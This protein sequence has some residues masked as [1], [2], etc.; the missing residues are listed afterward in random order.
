[1]VF[2][3]VPEGIINRSVEITIF[4]KVFKYVID[5]KLELKPVLAKNTKIDLKKIY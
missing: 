4:C 3:Y 1:M 2:I 5:I